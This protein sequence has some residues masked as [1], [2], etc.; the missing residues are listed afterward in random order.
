M[1]RAITV[2]VRP[3]GRSAPGGGEPR[4]T[5]EDPGLPGGDGLRPVVHLPAD[6]GTGHAPAAQ[7]AAVPAR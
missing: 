5:L 6:Q 1:N 4:L 7:D 3:R 2:R